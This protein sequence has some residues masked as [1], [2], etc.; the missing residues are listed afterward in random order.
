MSK[1]IPLLEEV[2]EFFGFFKLISYWINTS[3]NELV[4]DCIKN[5]DENVKIM[6]EKLLSGESVDF[7]YNDKVTYLDFDELKSINNILNLLFSSGYLTIAGYRI[8]EFNKK[9]TLVKISNDK[10]K[11]LFSNVLIEILKTDYK[12]DDLLIES[13]V[14]VY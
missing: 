12:I 7:I 8:N 9:V 1:F 6:I 3:G 2:G 11:S 10:V 14:A 4:K 5:C 13:F